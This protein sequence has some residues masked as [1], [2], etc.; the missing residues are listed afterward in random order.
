[1]TNI[2]PFESGLDRL[3]RKLELEARLF[4][5]RSRN[6]ATQRSRSWITVDLEFLYDRSRHKAYTTTEGRDAEEKIRWPFH[7]VAAISWMKIEFISGEPL[8][9]V[10]GPTVLAADVMDE[11]AMAAAFFTA[12]ED[13]PNAVVTTWG[14]ETRDLAVLRRAATTHRLQVPHQLIDGSPY[15]RER[16]DLCRATCVQAEP[17]HLDELA[18][19]VSVPAKPSPPKEI[20]K[21]CD[22]SSADRMPHVRH[23]DGHRRCNALR[24]PHQRFREADLR[25]VGARSEGR[26]RIAGRGLSSS[27]L[28]RGQT[29]EFGSGLLK[30]LR[31]KR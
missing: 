30:K 1:M 24:F 22:R 27:R 5:A 29:E 15:T 6:E 23:H 4:A 19:A 7:Q 18:A 31:R 25:P 12:L 10:E 3:A 11:R 2:V 14:G 17:V 26:E 13:N 9:I 20:G 8:P 16:L 28:N 21:L